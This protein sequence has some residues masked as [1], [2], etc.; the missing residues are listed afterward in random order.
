MRLHFMAHLGIAVWEPNPLPSCFREAGQQTSL[1]RGLVD[2]SQA[3][4]FVGLGS[5][6]GRGS[7]CL[8]SFT[9]CIP[10]CYDLGRSVSLTVWFRVQIKL[11]QWALPLHRVVFHLFRDPDKHHQGC[12]AQWFMTTPSLKHNVISGA[13]DALWW[14]LCHFFFLSEPEKP[15][16]ANQVSGPVLPDAN[17]TWDELFLP[18]ILRFLTAHLSPGS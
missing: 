6:E 8:W 12:S 1:M 9:R 7:V 17:V 13:C 15:T 18:K 4:C 16:G 11:W 2:T 3:S 5:L 14:F 10:F